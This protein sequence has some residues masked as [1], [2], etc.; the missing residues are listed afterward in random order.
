MDDTLWL[1]FCV[2]SV[3]WNMIR[4][5]QEKSSSHTSE[6]ADRVNCSKIGY[7]IIVM[8]MLHRCDTI[9]FYYQHK[10]D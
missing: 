1:F 10:L 5:W 8:Y 9:S 4:V 3:T 2:T 7:I 6:H